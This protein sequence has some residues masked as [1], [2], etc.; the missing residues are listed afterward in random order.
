MQ[1]S[2]DKERAPSLEREGGEGGRVIGARD[3][4]RDR[5]REREGEKRG[6]ETDGDSSGGE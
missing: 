5:K 6:C 4:K 3:R 2:G 1:R